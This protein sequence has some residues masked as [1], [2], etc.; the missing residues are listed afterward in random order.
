M[1]LAIMQPYLF[2]YLGYFQLIGSSDHFL[3][4]DDANFIKQ[5][6]INRNYI[7]VNKK[8][9]LFTVPLLKASSNSPINQTRINMDL[10]PRWKK[11][12]MKT[13]K[14]AYCKAKNFENIY[15]L[16]E[17][18]LQLEND[19]ISSLASDSVVEVSSYLNLRSRFTWTS[20]KHSNLS[21]NGVDR[22]IAIC[23]AEGADKYINLPG[24]KD[25]YKKSD[26]LENDL[27]LEFI[28]VIQKKYQQKSDH[29]VPNLS[30]IDILMNKDKKE[31]IQLVNNYSLG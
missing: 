7:L 8:P 4:L 9:T 15:P 1:R 10:Y 16:I 20:K 17:S 11:G 24:G 27:Q 5:G 18:I 29:F 28:E 25:L 13:L 23:K 14:Q 2:P 3:F 31:A 26:F 12:F 6:W 22:V 30:I 19:H 21:V